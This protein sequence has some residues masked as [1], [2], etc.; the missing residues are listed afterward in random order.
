MDI[1]RTSNYP[2][3]PPEQA[4]PSQENSETPRKA[5]GKALAPKHHWWTKECEERMQFLGASLWFGLGCNTAT[6]TKA[7]TTEGGE[8]HGE[9]G[10]ETGSGVG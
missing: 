1:E 6:S 8:A 9:M 3:V 5:S 10:A 7:T 2:A 4:T